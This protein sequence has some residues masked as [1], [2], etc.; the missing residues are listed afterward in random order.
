MKKIT[1]LIFM[2]FCA[3]GFSQNKATNA[4]ADQNSQTVLLPAAYYNSTVTAV[5]ETT[6]VTSNNE[7]DYTNLN[8]PFTGTYYFRSPDAVVY[9]NGPY[10]NV[11]GPPD[12]SFLQDASLGMGVYGFGASFINGFS[13]ADDVVLTDSYDIT[14][15][16]VFAYQTGSSAPSINA[17]YLQVW[18]GDP[19]GGGAT[20]I[21]GDLTTD[22]LDTAVAT[23]AFRQLES[24]PGDTSREIQRATALTPGLSLTP[25]TYWIEYS[26]EGS[27]S[28]GPWAPPIVITGN[29]T[30]GN[31][32]QNN[33]GVY[34]PVED[35]GSLTPQG[36]PFVMYG[37][38]VG[39]GTACNES[40]ASN[41]F[42]NGYTSS[43]D[44]PQHV[45]A[46]LT[47][48]MGE[49]MSFN[50][51]T[52]NFI[53]PD[54]DTVVSADITVYADDF[55]GLPDPGNV[56][57]SQTAVVPSSQTLL[58]DFPAASSLDVTEVVFDLAPIA[59]AGQAAFPT[60]YW[61]SIYVTTSAGTGGPGYWEITTAS[62]VGYPAVYSA[63]GGATWQ[64]AT[65]ADDFVY[66]FEGDC[67]PLGV[68]DNALG[69]FT[70][71][72]NPTSGTLSL[73]SVNNIDSVAIYNLLGQSVLSSTIGATTSDLD[74][75]S[76]ATGTYIMK[77][78]VE[79][80]TG[81]YKILK[82]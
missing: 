11:A 60:T 69:G 58:G 25:G 24:A 35:S 41:G 75:S 7:V 36:F 22:V 12:I 6:G 55:G 59:L 10:F 8:V 50:K 79:G 76:L 14:S 53:M 62:V 49:N 42:E 66:N 51:A 57:A 37:D 71:Y 20:V 63:D 54:G 44:T 52:A 18:D 21:W 15:I 74:V 23:D 48:A 70:Y 28:S 40:N 2:G 45:A 9:D 31:A 29:A 27:G 46:D 65:G 33:A 34:A 1:M 64:V 5:G 72:P 30:T 32:L 43:V 77:V 47:V 38:L 16:D 82:N 4:P 67:D 19:S 78:T 61:V 56:I 39:G 3:I 13:I 26:F 81:T 80:Q 17:L 73:K 68:A